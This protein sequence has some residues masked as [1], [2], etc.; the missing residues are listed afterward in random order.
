MIHEGEG[1][2]QRVW[3][4]L[5]FVHNAQSEFPPQ[6]CKFLVV[7]AHFVGG[8]CFRLANPLSSPRADIEVASA[9]LFSASLPASAVVEQVRC[10]LLATEQ[11]QGMCAA[12]VQE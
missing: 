12:H 9:A 3:I 8:R 6:L 11:C 1:R 2:W 10:F 7:F 4:H 5:H